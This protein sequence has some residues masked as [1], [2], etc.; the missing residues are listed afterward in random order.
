M[1]VQELSKEV[2]AFVESYVRVFDTFDS[3]RIAAFYHV[4]CVTVRADGCVHYRSNEEELRSFFQKV[5][6]TYR[7]QAWRRFRFRDLEVAAIG[8]RSALASLD[9][10]MLRGDAIAVSADATECLH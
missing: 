2:C 8:A 7:R 5:V 4:P 1:T 10:E 9:W 3:A 6:D